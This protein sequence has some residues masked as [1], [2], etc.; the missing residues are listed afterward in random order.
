[1]F[2]EAKTGAKMAMGHQQQFSESSSEAFVVDV[3]ALIDKGIKL[4]SK[5]LGHR[6]KVPKVAQGTAGGKG[7]RD[8]RKACYRLAWQD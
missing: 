7:R 6:S 3:G 8:G 2:V 5:T 1:M 4:A